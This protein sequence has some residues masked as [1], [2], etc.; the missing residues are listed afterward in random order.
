MH[1]AGSFFI[2]SEGAGYSK[3]LGFMLQDCCGTIPRVSARLRS[4]G[5]LPGKVCRHA[6]IKDVS[7]VRRSSGVRYAS[8]RHL[9]KMRDLSIFE[10]SELLEM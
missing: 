1:D 4:A 2:A 10:F 8:A 9:R 3:K 5:R 7:P 6:Q